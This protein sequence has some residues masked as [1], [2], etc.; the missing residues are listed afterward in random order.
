MYAYP[1]LLHYLVV[2]GLDQV[3]PPVLVNASLLKPTTKFRYYLNLCKAIG[4]AKV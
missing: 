4:E 3:V 2:D 1:P